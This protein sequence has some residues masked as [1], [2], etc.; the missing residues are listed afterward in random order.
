MSPRRFEFS[1]AA[2]LYAQNVDI[3]QE[4]KASD[5]AEAKRLFDANQGLISEMRAIAYQ[6]VATYGQIVLDELSRLPWE[7]EQCCLCEKKTYAS[8][9]YAGQSFN[10]RWLKPV[11]SV[12]KNGLAQ[13]AIPLPIPEK[14]QSIADDSKL[15][16]YFEVITKQQFPVSINYPPVTDPADALRR[17]QVFALCYDTRFGECQYEYRNGVGLAF[18]INTSDSVS[19]AV[20]TISELL[21]AIFA[22]EFQLDS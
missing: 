5:S 17:K 16:R 13:L 10:Y 11:A 12:R 20:N 4:V 22:I 7:M 6:E 14:I 15:V 3:V 9:S 19:S 8:K 1:P 18:P 2:Q 21:R